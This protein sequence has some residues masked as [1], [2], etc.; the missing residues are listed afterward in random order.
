MEA[1]S[2]AVRTRR[3]RPGTSSRRQS[4]AAGVLSPGSIR[5]AA[6]PGASK[7][8]GPR[9]RGSGSKMYART[10]SMT[11]AI[12]GLLSNEDTGRGRR[13]A[14]ES[15]LG[16]RVGPRPQPG[17]PHLR[18]DSGSEGARSDD[19]TGG[20]RRGPAGGQKGRGGCRGPWPQTR[21]MPPSF[22]GNWRPLAPQG[23]RWLANDTKM[24]QLRGQARSCDL[25]FAWRRAGG[26]PCGGSLTSRFGTSNQAAGHRTPRYGPPKCP[27]L[28]QLGWDPAYP[29][30]QARPAGWAGLRSHP[31]A[32]TSPTPRGPQAASSEPP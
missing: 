29:Q 31:A 9:G 21:R 23:I 11:L 4:P 19:D 12:L 5:D 13:T 28:L 16:A 30:P 15:T 3:P 2:S 14:L 32:P 6:L 8:P 7:W 25:G 24:G 17:Q 10:T 27:R 1:T 22:K 18:S 20:G 26:C